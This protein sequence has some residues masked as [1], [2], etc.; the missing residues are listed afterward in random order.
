M[1]EEYKLQLKELKERMKKAEAFALQCPIFS[2]KIL[3]DIITGEES[4][5]TFADKYKLL[6]TQNGIKRNHYSSNNKN[7][8]YIFNYKKE[9]DIF[10]WSI[11]INTLEEYNSINKYGLNEIHKKVP[12][13][14]YDN[15]NDAFY[16]TDDQIGDL[17]EALNDWKIHAVAQLKIDNRNKDIKEAEV[18]LKIATERLLCLKNEIMEKK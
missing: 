13:F 9:H 18:K 4:S 10:L 17:L 7:D 14:F 6:I 1:R 16:C 2:K 11:F 3:N 8:K 15:L 5:I 12:I